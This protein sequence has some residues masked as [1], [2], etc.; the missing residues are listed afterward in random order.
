[1]APCPLYHVAPSADQEGGCGGGASASGGP[2]GR[3]PVLDQWWSGEALQELQGL[4]HDDSRLCAEVTLPSNQA[5]GA[6]GGGGAGANPAAIINSINSSGLTVV[7]WQLLRSPA[8][9]AAA[10][11]STALFAGAAA[12]AAAASAPAAAA[13]AAGSA[14]AEEA[15][16]MQTKL[17]LVARRHILAL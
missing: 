11:C 3:H 1:M 17:R 12:A 15:P 4:M 6:G 7:A 14:A 13:A 8:P 16:A 9:A 10:T 2:G 5:R